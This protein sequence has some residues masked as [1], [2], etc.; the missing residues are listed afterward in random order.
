MPSKGTNK[1]IAQIDD[2]DPYEVPNNLWRTNIDNYPSI[3]FLDIV[4][5]LVLK[6]S[7]Y[8]LEEMG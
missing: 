1:K 4:S 6:T 7:A 3:S 2:I 5:Y 8:S